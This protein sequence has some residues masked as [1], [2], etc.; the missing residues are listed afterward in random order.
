M[1]YKKE[2]IKKVTQ[3]AMELTNVYREK[4]LGAIKICISKGNKKIGKVLNV[5]LMPVLTCG[6]CKHCQNICY[7]IK[8]CVQYVNV[9]DAR[10]RNT[11]LAKYFR[12]VY[13]FEIRLA[14]MRRRKN[15]YFR[16]H[17]AGD[18]LDD[19]YFCKMVE[20]ARDFPE[21]VFWTYTKM[22]HIVNEWCD[23]NGKENLPSNLSIMF[24]EWKIQKEDGT[25]EVVPFD[26]RY[27]FPVFAV[28]F[29]GEEKPD[30]HR[31]PGNCDICKET[32][33]GCPFGENS[34]ADEH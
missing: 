24:S 23:R 22:Y 29:K 2:T 7:D 9:L 26:N 11:V 3:K 33:H 31:C 16:W 14:C 25:Y 28:R 34:Y 20:I 8:A 15:K 6:N 21:F 12:D 4:G 32:R 30:M 27:G 19:D 1:A 13:F 5:S 10:V 17:V 18:I